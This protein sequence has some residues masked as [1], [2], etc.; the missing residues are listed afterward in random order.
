M[1]SITVESYTSDDTKLSNQQYTHIFKSSGCLI[2]EISTTIDI[3]LA[4]D[5]SIMIRPSNYNMCVCNEDIIFISQL[6]SDSETLYQTM[7]G[8][9]NMGKYMKYVT[10]GLA[11]IGVI[12]A[13]VPKMLMDGKVTVGEASDFV[14]DV[15]DAAGWD[16]KLSVPDELR[17]VDLGIV[18]RE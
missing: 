4:L 18:P 16:I 2:K 15:C 9:D 12:V 5:R 11:V 10:R 17:D 6:M 14:V 8:G 13:A 3:S 7:K 1:K